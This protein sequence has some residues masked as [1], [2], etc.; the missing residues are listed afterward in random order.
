MSARLRGKLEGTADYTD[1]PNSK[2]KLPAEMRHGAI[3]KM[4]AISHADGAVPRL[5]GRAVA[6]SLC[7]GVSRKTPATQRRNYNV[8]A[9]TDC[10][11][12]L[13]SVVC[14]PPSARSPFEFA[15]PAL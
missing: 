12:L 6:A 4:I 8:A 11:Q 5:I 9:V 1:F 10:S 15:R 14:R 3:P 2:Q 13:S 7:R